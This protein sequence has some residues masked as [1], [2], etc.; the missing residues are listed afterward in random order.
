M[1]LKAR[2]K[3]LEAAIPMVMPKIFIIR[4]QPTAAQQAA[5]TECQRLCRPFK[6]ITIL[7]AEVQHGH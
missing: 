5:I 4:E 2:I 6:T 3:K 1:N 7:K